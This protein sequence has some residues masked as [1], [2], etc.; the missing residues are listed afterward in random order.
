MDKP[1]MIGLYYQM[2]DL[3]NIKFKYAY[4]VIGESQVASYKYVILL[5]EFH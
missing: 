1:F 2:L 5:S 4:F 3:K